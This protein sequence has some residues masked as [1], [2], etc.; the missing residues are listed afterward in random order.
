M[1]RF[2]FRHV[3]LFLLVTLAL[4]AT[5]CLG[6][7]GGRTY[8]LTITVVDDASSDEIAG[9]TVVI[10]SETKTTGENGRVV[11]TD[12]SGTVT[13]ETTAEGFAVDSRTVNMNQNR[14]ITIRLG[15]PTIAAIVASSDNFSTLLVALEAAD[16]ADT[17]AGEGPFTV[18][19][20]TDAAFA[21]LPEGVLGDLLDDPEGAL[22]DVLLY[23]VVSGKVMA[24]TVLTLDGEEVDTLLVGATILITIDGNTVLVNE[25]TVTQTDIEASNGVI[26]VID[27]VL[28]PPTNDNDL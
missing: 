10:G 8:D 14:S 13:V 11:F 2:N 25:S 20:P 4:F 3:G 6:I 24:E 9:A 22:T 17:L 1:E 27:A 19:A 15:L 7:F 12:L 26:H 28:L 16:L 21:A 5:G 18:F 23:H